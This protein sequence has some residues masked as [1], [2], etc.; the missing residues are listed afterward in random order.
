MSLQ[1]FFGVTGTLRLGIKNIVMT[2]YTFFLE[3][4]RII[5]DCL[6]EIL[7]NN[8][9]KILGAVVSYAISKVILWITRR[10]NWKTENE[11]SLTV[12]EGYSCCKVQTHILNFLKVVERQMAKGNSRRSR[13]G[14]CS[15]EDCRLDTVGYNTG[16]RPRLQTGQRAWLFTSAAETNKA[17]LLKFCPLACKL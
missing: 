8:Y 9:F 14:R 17:P 12:L 4:A 15:P 10:I 6:T 2:S 1:D 3:L 16:R 7:L 11:R 13:D 5:Y